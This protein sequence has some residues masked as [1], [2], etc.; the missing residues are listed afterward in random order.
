MTMTNSDIIAAMRARG[1]DSGDLDDAALAAIITQ[2][3]TEYNRYRPLIKCRTFDTVADQQVYTW[4]Q[5]GDS[6]GWMVMYCLWSPYITGN[7]W[8]LAR[9]LATLGV[10]GDPAY[11]HMPSQAE[12]ESI[13]AAAMARTYG[14]SGYQNDI[15]GG[16]LYLDPVPG[17]AGDSVYIL[18]T[19][20][21]VSVATV[22]PQDLDIFCDLLE[23]YCSSRLALA[24]A[25]AAVAVWIKTPE[26]E[27]RVDGQIQFWRTHASDMRMQFIDKA[28]AG[29]SPA[30]RS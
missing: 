23:A 5:M 22:K 2:A 1:I 16:D 28:S 15:E 7:E 11:Y 6:T 10:P 8:D 14:G 30:M 27:R 20:K 13:K 18:Y 17:E 24:L 21:H 25:K 19:A 26:Y 12:I 3:L 4:T 29:A 9:T